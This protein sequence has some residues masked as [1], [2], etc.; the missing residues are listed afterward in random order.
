MAEI[1]TVTT[2]RDK[3]DEILHSNGVGA[4]LIGDRS[5][6]FFLTKKLAP[7]NLGLL[8]HYRAVSGHSSRLMACPL[9][10]NSDA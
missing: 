4:I 10:A 3:R 5:N 9:S 2:L 1:R 8:Q 7:N 6:Y